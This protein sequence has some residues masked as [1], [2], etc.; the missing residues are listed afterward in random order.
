MEL[1]IRERGLHPTPTFKRYFQRRLRHALRSFDVDR[2]T[3]R[4]LRNPRAGRHASYNCRV[5]V[6]SH[7]LGSFRVNETHATIRVAC[8]RAANKTRRILVRLFHRARR[9]MRKQGRHH[10]GVVS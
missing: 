3:V 9:R 2:V 1:M 7:G 5:A 6:A 4:L 8:V 10:G